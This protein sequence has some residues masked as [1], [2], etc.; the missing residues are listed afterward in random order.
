M[1]RVKPDYS[2]T[3]PFQWKKIIGSVRDIG[4]YQLLNNLQ[5]DIKNVLNE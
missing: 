2:I 1:I 4:L 5:P 3:K